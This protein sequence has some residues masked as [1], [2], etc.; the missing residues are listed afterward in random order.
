MLF[1]QE[2]NY[3]V[4]AIRALSS[5]KRVKVQE[6]CK[7]ENIPSTFAYKILKKLEHGGFVQSTQ[8]TY[9]GYILVKELNS[10]S[11]LDIYIAIDKDLFVSKYL[12]VG[13]RCKNRN[14]LK[15]CVLHETLEKLQGTVT[16]ILK[17]TKLD[18]LV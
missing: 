12:K 6:I 11:L 9:G 7:N 5:M 16:R 18:A 3:A 17:R 2:Q 10:I 8:G 13:N 4:K 1:T 14:G 15:N